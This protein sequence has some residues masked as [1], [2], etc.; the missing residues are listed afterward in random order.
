MTFGKISVY[1][2]IVS[3][4]ISL[5]VNTIAVLVSSYLL[6]GVKVDGFGTAV[7]VAIV[8]GIVNAFLKPILILLT[9]PINILTF[10]LFT[11]VINALLV[12]LVGN[13]V[14]GFHVSGFL[15]A[16]A[17]SLVLAVIS[18]FLYSIA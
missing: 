4:I 9:L 15:W 18:A 17:F 16:L 8:L 13:I 6:P 3:L 5:L 2:N 11:F 12:L 14:P 10:G 7:V 1:Y